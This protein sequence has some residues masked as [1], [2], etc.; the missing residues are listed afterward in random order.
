MEELLANPAIQGGVA[1]FVVAFIIALIFLRVNLIAGLVVVAGFSTVIFLTTGFSFSPLSSA[2]KI[3]LLVLLV[4]VIGILLQLSGKFS[5]SIIKACYGLTALAIV[6]LMWPVLN[7]NPLEEL[8]PVLSY[9]IYAA[10]MMAIFM[11]MS[12]LPAHTAGT[13]ATAVG[14]AI[15]GCAVIGASGLYGQL[16]MSLGAASGA[17]LLLQLISRRTEDAGLTFTMSSGIIAALLLPA[18]IVYS[19]VPWII[20][21]LV[22]LIPLMA[23]YSFIDE[24][25]V[26]K[27][28]ISLFATMAIPIGLALYITWQT[29]GA[30]LL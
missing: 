24:D 26:W 1:P 8:I 16:G 21:P 11:K 5:D 12:E 6:W 25:S 7:R 23:M 22:A 17:F 2:R 28:T 30:L 19:K 4:P 10:W 13:A 3:T 18:S 29:A 20:M 27:N 9:M 15:G 14:I